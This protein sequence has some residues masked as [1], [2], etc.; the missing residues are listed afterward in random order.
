MAKKKASNRYGFTPEIKAETL[1]L[2]RDEGYTAKQAAEFAGCSLNA[3]NDWKA[4]AKAGKIK[5]AVKSTTNGAKTAEPTVKSVK[6]AKKTKRR[7]KGKKAATVVVAPAD[8]PSI[9]FDEFVQD[10]WKK[11][12]GASDVLRLPAD[13]MPKA[14]QHVNNVLR[15]AYNQ[16]CEK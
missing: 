6:K 3:I 16:F 13:I 8:K 10:Y 9:T 11:C 15:Y 12:A 7:R 2:I 1:R 14:V 4:A 5:V